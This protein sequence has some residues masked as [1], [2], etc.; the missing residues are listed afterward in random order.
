MSETYLEIRDRMV[1]KRNDMIQQG[2]FSLSIVEQKIL[3]CLI[4]RIN[5]WDTDLKPTEF[6]IPEFCR[7]CGIE[8]EGGTTYRYL[9]DGVKKLADK[10][11]YITGDEPNTIKLV[12]WISDAVFDVDNKGNIIG[13]KMVLKLSDNMK[14]YL[15]QLRKYYTQYEL[16]YT[17]RFKS[18]F[19]IRL[20]EYVQS[21]HY[22]KR[23]PY[24]HVVSVDN[25]REVMGADHYKTWQH[26]KDRA[27]LPALK[28][29]NTLS[30]KQ[31]SYDLILT[32]RKTT[33][34]SLAIASKP[35]LERVKV[36]S[37]AEEELGTN[38]MTLWDQLLEKGYVT[39]EQQEPGP[40][41]PRQ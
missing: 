33:G 27:F 23:K 21:V 40:E 31:I 25:L 32:G 12:R 9:K 3:L 38:Q 15:L 37:E 6:N 4:A 13:G 16:I 10:S 34:I 39:D 19:S 24:A 17:L 41:Q 22:D 18:K 2:R 1:R 11:W 20:Y 7:I 28:E 8:T 35:P 30:D 36:R 26:F 5:P 14:D 29:I